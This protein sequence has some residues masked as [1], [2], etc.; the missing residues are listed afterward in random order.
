MQYSQVFWCFVR[1]AAELEFISPQFTPCFFDLIYFHPLE[2]SPKVVIGEF[3]AF[4]S[5][6]LSQTYLE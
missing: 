2:S 4:H 5:L 1:F 3:T 6:V